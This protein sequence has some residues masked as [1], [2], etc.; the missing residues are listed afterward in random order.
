MITTPMSIATS[1]ARNI[2]AKLARTAS[3]TSPNALCPTAAFQVFMNASCGEVKRR[4]HSSDCAWYQRS[5]SPVWI[6]R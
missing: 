5:Q 4:Y 6:L 1:S 2:H 3:L